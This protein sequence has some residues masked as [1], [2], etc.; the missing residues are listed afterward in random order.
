[1]K[2]LLCERNFEG[3]KE[4]YIKGLATSQE[5]EIFGY[6]PKN[7]GL[8]KRHFFKC[9]ELKDRKSFLEYIA[10]IKNIKKLVEKERIEIV[11]ILDGDSIMRFFGLGFNTIQCKIVVTYHHFFEG[12][13]RK[14]SYKRMVGKKNRICVAHTESVKNKLISCGLNNVEL[15][16]YPVFEMQYISTLNSDSCK[17]KWGCSKEI[18]VIGII[19][20]ICEYKNILPFLKVLRNLSIPFQILLCGKEQDIKETQIKQCIQSYSD[21][22]ITKFGVLTNEEYY[23]AIIASDIIFC[24]YGLEFDGASGP[25]TDGVCGNKMILS[26]SHGSLGK[27]VKE[28]HLGYT[29]DCTNIE[30]IYRKTEKAISSIKCF[31][32]DEKA[33]AYKQSLKLEKFV[34][35]Y[36]DIYSFEERLGK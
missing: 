16:Y 12:K 2:V 19:G 25:L 32:Y 3:H 6:C 26:C 22:V 35:R 15:C 31:K 17:E 27:I 34:L 10:W 8:D 21:K 1:M 5:D 11:H 24:I 9:E 13:M 4:N 23:T 20:G 14:M 30:D 28:N 18:P 29:A 7:I 36:H 33:E